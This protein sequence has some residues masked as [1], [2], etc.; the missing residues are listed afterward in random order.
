MESSLLQRHQGN[1]CS[2]SCC[3]CCLCWLLLLLA[4]KPNSLLLLL[5]GVQQSEPAGLP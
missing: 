1:A 2:L 4:R 5:L 3:C